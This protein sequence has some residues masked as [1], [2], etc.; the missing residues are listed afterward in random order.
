M[1]TCARDACWSQRLRHLRLRRVS[2]TPHSIAYGVM[3]VRHQS[4]RTKWCTT[5][6]DVVSAPP[7]SRRCR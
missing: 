3:Q 7:A 6:V 5:N 4:A 2:L 1:L